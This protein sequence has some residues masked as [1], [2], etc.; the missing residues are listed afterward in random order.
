MPGPSPVR[1]LSLLLRRGV[2]GW[3]QA[4]SELP[5][6]LPEKTRKRRASEERDEVVSLLVEMAIQAEGYARRRPSTGD[7]RTYQG[8]GG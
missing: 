3:M 7:R 6:P 1:G 8:L 5:P 4:W 2:A